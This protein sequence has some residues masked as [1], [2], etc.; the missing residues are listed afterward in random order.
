MTRLRRIERAD[1]YF[2]VTTSLVRGI[3]ALSAR[4]RGVCL[5]FLGKARSKH[6]FALFGYV[7]MPDHAHL[8]LAAFQSTLPKLM[9]DWKSESGFAIAQARHTR[10]GIWQRRY[11]DFILR[12]VADFGK[13]MEYIHDNPVAAGLVAR[14]EDWAWSSAA[15]YLRK[16]RAAV[17]PD[18][19]EGPADRDEPLWPVPWR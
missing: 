15:F 12:R 9:R 1:R 2:F 7:I 18:I 19:F 10:G 14:P 8:L 11:F 13:K 6:G 17:R 5:E 3:P 16:E 4:E